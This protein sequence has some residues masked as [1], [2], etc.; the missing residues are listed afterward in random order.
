[1]TAHP[2]K[3]L[4]LWISLGLF[5]IRGTNLA[6]FTLSVWKMIGRWD[7]L[8]HPCFQSILGCTA[9]NQEYPRMA[10]CSPKSNR[11]NLIVVQLVPI[12]T[13]RSVYHWSSPVLVLV[14]STLN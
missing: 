9:A 2:M 10:L 11:K 3:Y 14:P 12:W 7:E 1:M 4:S 6:F 8:I 13:L 5:T